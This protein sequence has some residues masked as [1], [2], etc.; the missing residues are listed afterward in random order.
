M[1]RKINL[2]LFLILLGNIPLFSQF[3]GTSHFDSTFTE[4]FRRNSG[5]WTAGDAT[6]S[7]PLSDGRVIW[8]FGDS[9]IV[10]VDTN[11]NTLPCL[12][13]I[14][15]CMMVQDSIERS[16]FITYID[17][18]E[19][20][21]NRTTFKLPGSS[22]L[23]LLWP[24]HG[25]EYQ[26]T[27]YI[28][29]EHLDN[30]TWELIDMYVAKLA[31]PGLQLV[32]MAVLPDRGDFVF[33]RYVL[34]DS[35][36]GYRYIYGNKVNWIVQEPFLA[37]CPLDGLFGTWEYWTGT[38][39]S[40]NIMMI[41]K[42]SELPVS[43][44]FSVVQIEDRYYLIT[45]ENGYLTCGL[46]REIYSYESDY[47][48]GP[49]VNQALLYTEE[50]KIGEHYLLTYNA[51]SHPEFTENNELLISYNVN[52]WVDTIN[53]YIC[54]SQCVNVWTDRMDADSYRPKFVRVP[55]GLITG[56]EEEN[57]GQ[58]AGKFYPNPAKP[59]VSIFWQHPVKSTDS[60]ELTVTDLTGKIPDHLLHLNKYG[61]IAPPF[62]GIY[63][64]SIFYNEKIFTGKLVIL[65]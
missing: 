3:Y 58:P 61:F 22:Q 40:E 17:S 59:G 34:T 16:H 5:G 39:W 53:P 41:Q 62:P 19:T 63:V 50:S 10:D 33:G 21:I 1:Q 8:L 47:I 28:F 12:F 20:G 45:Q 52:D 32:Q 15:N 36:A 14:R 23:Q 31:M 37:R 57:T 38:G 48:T 30:D 9:Y 27:V 2:I 29:F 64:V 26:D 46:G 44:N 13:Q 49:F 51:M 54:P 11:D 42:I 60:M 6:I 56:I 25:F 18:A 43:P 65:P 24:D 4:Y 7:I 55:L 35:V